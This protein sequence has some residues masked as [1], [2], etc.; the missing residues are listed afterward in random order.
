M[1]RADSKQSIS[2]SHYCDLVENRSRNLTINGTARLNLSLEEGMLIPPLIFM[3]FHCSRCIFSRMTCL[4]HQQALAK[5]FKYCSMVHTHTPVCVCVC[6][7]K[8]L[9]DPDNA[10][11]PGSKRL[12]C[13]F[14]IDPNLLLV[15]ESWKT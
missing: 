15:T 5:R 8:P 11:K 3:Y 1:L 13:H 7:T 4:Q 12:K 9:Y 6:T 14:W 10:R 2:P